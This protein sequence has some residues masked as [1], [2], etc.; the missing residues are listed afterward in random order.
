MDMNFKIVENKEQI[1][2]YTTFSNGTEHFV[3][4]F[5]TVEAVNNFI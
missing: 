4:S 3:S 5:P 2:L 1:D